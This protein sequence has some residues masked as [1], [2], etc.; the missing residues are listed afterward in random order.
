M[1]PAVAALRAAAADV[2]VNDP[3]VPL[4]S[5]AD[6]AAVSSGADWLERIVNQVSA[7]VRWD[8]CMR[9]MASMDVSAMI[10]LP[11]SGTLTGL[12]RRTLPGV[13]LLAVKTPDDLAAARAM[14]TE[15]A[16]HAF[17]HSDTHA[18][19][20]QL[21]VAAE[22]GKFRH[23]GDGPSLVPGA[24]VGAGAQMG[25]IET[26][27]GGAAVAARFPGTIIEWLVENG[28][29]VSQG[30]PLVRLQ[31]AGHDYESAQERQ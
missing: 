22:R 15:H 17:G 10:E 6:G 4:L 29:P 23:L 28:D 7:P 13:R 24:A 18:P 11:P 19:E 2:K 26:R 27:S 5:N 14:L 8:L 30:Q 20:W 3:A 21:V 25:R 1:A 31:P 16:D 12:A 9:T